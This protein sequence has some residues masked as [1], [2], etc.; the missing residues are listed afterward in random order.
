MASGS[1]PLVLCW[2]WCKGALQPWW[3]TDPLFS[4]P[5]THP[6]TLPSKGS[7]L[8]D[9]WGGVSSRGSLGWVCKQ[10][11]KD[12]PLGRG[13][14]PDLSGAGLLLFDPLLS[15][16]FASCSWEHLS[17]RVCPHSTQL[18]GWEWSLSLPK[19]PPKL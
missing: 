3:E 4:L 12:L 6:L 16:L 5:H 18:L 2:V 1:W 11:C 9:G 13:N 15:S 19:S 10:L 8:G 7:A 17:L 14:T